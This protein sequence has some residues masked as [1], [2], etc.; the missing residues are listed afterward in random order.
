[1]A[2]EAVDITIK[3]NTDTGQ[4]DLLSSK[5]KDTDFS[6]QHLLQTV[7]IAASAGAFVKFL[8]DSVEAAEQESESLRRIAF[9]VDA[10][11]GSFEQSKGKLEAWARAMQ[12]STR[13]SDTDALSAVEKLVVATNNLGQAQTAAKLAMDISSA[14]GKPLVEV[15]QVLFD[16][17]N[18]NNRALMES[19]RAFG[20]L[21]SV[22]D[23]NQ[24]IIEKLSTKFSGA[25]ESE[26]SLTAETAKLSHAF[27]D[28]EKDIGK[29]V[30][31]VMQRV[32]ERL[33]EGSKD[34]AS[35]ASAQVQA[36][37][38][39]TAAWTT[40]G[41]SKIPGAIEPLK[42]ALEDIAGIGD[43]AKKSIDD[44]GKSF[45]DMAIVA[46]DALFQVKQEYEAMLNSQLRGNAAL[47]ADY[48]ER[49][50]E[51]VTAHKQ[52]MFFMRDLSKQVA[53]EFVKDFSGAIAQTIVEGKSLADA[54]VNVF[55]RIIEMVIQAII[56]M[57]IFRTIAS[58]MPGGQLGGFMPWGAAGAPSAPKMPNTPGS[59]YNQN[60]SSVRMAVGH[61]NNLSQY[62]AK[63]YAF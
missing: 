2:D 35:W 49:T 37:T 14:S 58:A 9:F 44:V 19:R 8:K 50:A 28:L 46:K 52:T 24:Q 34:I 48:K 53:T 63:N 55:Q 23:T 47:V 27:E 4:L 32:G 62:T 40:L 6:M 43:N 1:M 3:V 12:E 26:K 60:P 42:K 15:Q 54:M 21:I 30:A 56:Q 16:V 36:L 29:P 18:G 33:Q 61:L 17:I 5:F 39:F 31:N 38:K 25:A 13:F 41:T 59:P 10:A 7:G 22:A 51:L 45:G 20:D 11:G 57:I